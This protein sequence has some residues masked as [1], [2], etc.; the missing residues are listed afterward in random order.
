MTS[1][2]RVNVIRVMFESLNGKFDR[3]RDYLNN[4][5][6]SVVRVGSRILGVVCFVIALVYA[7]LCWR[8]FQV[9]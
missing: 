1:W 3:L 2:K 9:M 5:E 8:Q 7:V 6:S 4:N